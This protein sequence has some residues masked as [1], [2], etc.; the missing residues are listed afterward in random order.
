MNSQGMV[1]TQQELHLLKRL[2]GRKLIN[3]SFEDNSAQ[4]ISDFVVVNADDL[5][6][7]ILGDVYE[8]DFEGFTELYSTLE[9]FS[10]EEHRDFSEDDSSEL[11]LTY[12]GEMIG[13]VLLV[14][15]KIICCSALVQD[16]ELIA[17]SGI[18]LVMDEGY[19]GISKLSYHDE[20][21]EVSYI[22]SL[23]L[24][25]VPAT[26]GR[27]ENGTSANYSYARNFVSILNSK[28]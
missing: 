26:L 16:W 21:I 12:E 15:D 3:L 19:I 1:F 10:K 14:C 18:V 22:S 17:H 28:I 20:Q 13:D 2:I 6:V 5:S 25:S 24:K 27:F 11:Y 23:E 4:L 7:C 9:V 8:D